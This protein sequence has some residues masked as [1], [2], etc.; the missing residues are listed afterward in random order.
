MSLIT[1]A[2]LKS[3][4]EVDSTLDDA[5][6]QDRI[7]VW[8][9]WI[10][11]MTANVFAVP[12]ADETWQVRGSGNNTLHWKIPI[13]SLTSISVLET[14]VTFD[15]SVYTYAPGTYYYKRSGG[16]KIIL[17]DNH[18]LD[19][20]SV[21]FS[22][23]PGTNL[24]FHSKWTYNVT[25]KF[26]TVIPDP[27]NVGQYIAPKPVLYLIKKLVVRDLTP[28][29]KNQGSSI[30]PSMLTEEKT[31]LHRRKFSNEVSADSPTGDRQLD[32]IL[33]TYRAMRTASVVVT[34]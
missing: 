18:T 4:E 27:D 10:E 30:Y 1:P 11:D 13:H 20:S 33:L 34:G 12:A 25:G 16:P 17:K 21:W 31:D 26:C 23:D 29:D 24:K 8:Q 9:S 32:R 14:G 6:I 3:L 19:S 5:F 7:D 28:M 2:E 15:P 22:G